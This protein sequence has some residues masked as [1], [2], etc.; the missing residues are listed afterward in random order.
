MIHNKN[1]KQESQSKADKFRKFRFRSQWLVAGLRVE[2][3]QKQILD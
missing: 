2:L 1:L 3:R